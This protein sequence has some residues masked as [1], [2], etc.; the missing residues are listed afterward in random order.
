MC[1]TDSF[2]LYFIVFFQLLQRRGPVQ[3]Y[4]FHLVPRLRM[5]GAMPPPN[6]LD[7][8]V[9]WDNFAFH[10]ILIISVQFQ[11]AVF[12]LKLHE[13]LQK[14]QII[15]EDVARGDGEP[16]T[17]KHMMVS[18]RNFLKQVVR[19]FHTHT[20]T[21]TLHDINALRLFLPRCLIP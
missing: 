3:E 17:L 11:A 4:S 6:I 7:Y 16:L 10:H 8:G 2:L 19:H 21:H 13:D 15:L 20:H 5:N 18:T 14:F 1:L 12:L 9:H